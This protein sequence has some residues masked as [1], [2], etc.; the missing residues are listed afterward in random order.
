[1]AI[2]RLVSGK[3]LSSS[4]IKIGTFSK[5]SHVDLMTR[6]GKLLGARMDGG[7]QI[8]EAGYDVPFVE[9]AYVDVPLTA[10]REEAVWRFA[11][12]QVGKGYDMSAILGIAFRRDWREDDKWFCSELVAAAFEAAGKPL[13]N[14]QEMRNRITPRDIAL[15]PFVQYRI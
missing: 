5:W 10:S 13:L 2:I 8:R 6:D 3:G 1:M 14:T 15:S 12:E 11:L 4:L 7:V 9:Q